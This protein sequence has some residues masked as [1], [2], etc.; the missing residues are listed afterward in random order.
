ME[1]L[2]RK[3]YCCSVKDLESEQHLQ[4]LPSG[5]RPFAAFIENEVDRKAL[6]VI[7]YPA[8]AVC[9]NPITSSLTPIMFNAEEL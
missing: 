4:A 6:E 7:R 5:S 9:S 3:E 1:K 2:R 8:A